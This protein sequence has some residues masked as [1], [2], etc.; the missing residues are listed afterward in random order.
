[1]RPKKYTD[2]QLFLDYLNASN[3]AGKWLRSHE[4]GPK[5]GLAYYKTYSKRFGENYKYQKID[6]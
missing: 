6:C 1:M 5:T 3:K 4:I 2:E